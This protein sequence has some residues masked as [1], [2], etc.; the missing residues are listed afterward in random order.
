MKR[1]A[2]YFLAALAAVSAFPGQVR[3]QTAIDIDGAFVVA[4]TQGNN[5][6][7]DMAFL[8]LKRSKTDEALSFAHRMIEDHT[9]LVARFNKLVPPGNVVVPERENAADRLALARLAK[10]PPADMD[11]EYLIQQVGDHLATV[12][13]FTTE[14]RDGANPALRAFANSEL[15]MLKEHLQVALMDAKRVGGDNPLRSQ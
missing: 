1:V 9:A 4:A 15:P 10:L 8:V 12:S 2:V 11:Q 7:I 13:V 3:A 5:A 14:A 6:E